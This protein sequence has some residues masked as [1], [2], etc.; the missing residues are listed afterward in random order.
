MKLE[1]GFFDL[2]KEVFTPPSTERKRS[3]TAFEG[4]LPPVQQ[5]AQEVDVGEFHSNLEERHLHSDLEEKEASLDEYPSEKKG[6]RA[7]DLIL[8]Q[9]ILSLPRSLRP[10]K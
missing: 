6:K 9:E 8:G 4:T 3:V 5:I 1:S 10:W 7:R 2:L